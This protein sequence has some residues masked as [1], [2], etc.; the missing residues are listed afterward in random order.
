[1][2]FHTYESFITNPSHSN[3]Y[4]LPVFA[5]QPANATV[6]TAAIGV[7]SECDGKFV[8]QGKVE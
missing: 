3:C 1:M 5:F 2:K 4:F 6:I 7:Y 8:I